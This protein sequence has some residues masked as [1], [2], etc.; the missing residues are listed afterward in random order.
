MPKK[1]FAVTNLKIGTGEDE[2]FV[3]G[4]VVDRSKFTDKQLLDLHEAGAIEVRVVDEDV[5]PDGTAMAEVI[6]TT[7]STESTE[8]PEV[9]PDGE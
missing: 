1:I 9:T 2:Y 5:A 7:E 6:A 8:T 4:A 3:A